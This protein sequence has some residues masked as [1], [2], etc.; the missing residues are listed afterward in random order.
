MI[1][2]ADKPIQSCQKVCMGK[3]AIVEVMIAGCQPPFRRT[4]GT[5]DLI[6]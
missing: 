4:Q 6:E 1:L 3:Q 5:V 2:L